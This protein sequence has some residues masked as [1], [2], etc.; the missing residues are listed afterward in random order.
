MLFLPL[1][2]EDST[3]LRTNLQRQHDVLERDTRKSIHT[4]DG[5]LTLTVKYNPPEVGYADTNS[6]TLIA[7]HIHDAPP[8][9]LSCQ[10]HYDSGDTNTKP[11]REVP[12][13]LKEIQK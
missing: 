5:R 9:S 8:I 6:A 1:D 4:L 2:R 10:L 12:P 7:I 3:N 11:Q 13:H